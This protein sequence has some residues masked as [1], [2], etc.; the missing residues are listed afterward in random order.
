MNNF[1][2]QKLMSVKKKEEEKK[3]GVMLYQIG[4]RIVMANIEMN[5]FTVEISKGLLKS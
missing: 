3:N 1:M 5:I 2:F 4:G